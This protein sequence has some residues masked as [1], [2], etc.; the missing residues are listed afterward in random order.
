M[1]CCLC[2]TGQCL[3]GSLNSARIVPSTAIASSKWEPYRNWALNG[4]PKS[5]PGRAELQRARQQVLV[6]LPS[7]CSLSIFQFPST[8][9]CPLNTFPNTLR[10]PPGSPERAAR[11]SGARYAGVVCLRMFSSSIAM[12]RGLLNTCTL[13]AA[14]AYYHASHLALQGVGKGLVNTVKH[15]IARWTGINVLHRRPHLHTL[16]A[17]NLHPHHAYNTCLMQSNDSSIKDGTRRMQ[18]QVPWSW[19]TAYSA[20]C[21]VS[22]C[23]LLCEYLPAAGWLHCQSRI[24]PT[25]RWCAAAHSLP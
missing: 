14:Y 11:T 22:T 15:G 23:L 8:P 17:H 12:S 9:R 21:C 10:E 24:A 13:G 7:A 3:G 25:G 20:C 1:G 2:S 5:A 4:S 6:Q 18:R 16:T 19:D